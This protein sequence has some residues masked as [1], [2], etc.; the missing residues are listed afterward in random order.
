MENSTRQ[1]KKKG[2]WIWLCC[3]IL[4]AGVFLFAAYKLFDYWWESHQ[5]E[6][7]AQELMQGAVSVTLPAQSAPKKE[8]P[9]EDA[10]EEP[11]E[12]IPLTPITVDFSL[13]A[14]Q[15]EDIVGW[16]Y[17]ENTPINYP[18]AQASNNDYY[19]RRLLDGTYNYG[20]TLFMDCRNAPDAS[21]WNTVIYGH[22]MQDDTMF[23]SLLDYK[24]QAYYEEHPV[25][26]YF[27]PQ[28]S[29]KVELIG[30]YLTDAYSDVYT[31]PANEQER[32]EL[33]A[34]VQ[35]HST[36]DSG[37]TWEADSRLLMLATCSYEAQHSRYV[38]LGKLVPVEVFETEVPAP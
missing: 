6:Q 7:Y 9:A 24:K 3:L 26:W 30:G 4:C 18:V 14:A 29:Y 22:S 34:L 12:K 23:G 38:L 11:E 1:K 10:P 15:S 5:R 25:L 36:F 27:T 2:G 19:L 35:Q 21:D 28:A 37:I 17:S 13:L 8:T 20:G 16:I 32:D 31:L 33:A